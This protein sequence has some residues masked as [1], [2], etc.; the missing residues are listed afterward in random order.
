MNTN[1]VWPAPTQAKTE[2]EDFD[3]S[4]IATTSSQ[5]IYEA[6]RGRQRATSSPLGCKRPANGL[7]VLSEQTTTARWPAHLGPIIITVPAQAK[8]PSCEKNFSRT[9]IKF[10]NREARHTTRRYSRETS[11]VTG[12]VDWICCEQ[13]VS[14][15]SFSPQ[16]HLLCR[17]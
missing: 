14:D 7:S 5:S 13:S 11:R 3:S 4:A 10:A 17:W 12:K 6:A 15:P 1:R 8:Y 2:R 9:P 16:P